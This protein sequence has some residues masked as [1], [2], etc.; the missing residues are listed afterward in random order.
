MFR[1]STASNKEYFRIF[2]LLN[3]TKYST[4]ELHSHETN[5][6]P[7][8]LPR[9]NDYGGCLITVTATVELC[10]VVAT[11]VNVVAVKAM[12]VAVVLMA[13]P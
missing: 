5:L 2:P 3:S 1:E 7:I 9:R 4:S 8:F 6:N 11:A 10:Y 12:V 13:T